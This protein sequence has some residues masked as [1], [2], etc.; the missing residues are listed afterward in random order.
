MDRFMNFSQPILIY[1]LNMLVCS[2]TS[3]FLLLIATDVNL[4]MES[5]SRISLCDYILYTIKALVKSV[6]VVKGLLWLI[7]L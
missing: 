5:T 7:L 1:I 6:C 4:T 3:R 2:Y